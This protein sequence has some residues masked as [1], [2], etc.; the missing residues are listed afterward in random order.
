MRHGSRNNTI[1]QEPELSNSGKEI[2][3][4]IDRSRIVAA[5]SDEEIELVQFLPHLAAEHLAA[6]SRIFAS[7]L[8]ARQDR[9]GIALVE[10][11]EADHIF[12]RYVLVRFRKQELVACGVDEGFP[13]VFEVVSQP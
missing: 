12:L 6:L 13:L 11:E 5:V 8:Q 9:V 3:R 4:R 2:E 10:G 7:V 1:D